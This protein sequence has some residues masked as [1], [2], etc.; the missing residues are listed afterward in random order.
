[1][2][3]LERLQD[4][5]LLKTDSYIGGKWQSSTKTFSVYNP[6]A[7]HQ[8]V[9]VSDAESTLAIQAILSARDALDGWKQTSATARAKA[10][11][12]WYALMIEAQSDLATILTWEQGKPLAE[13]AQEIA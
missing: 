7:T 10:L 4:K 3:L 6:A 5:G 11:L 2:A 9:E 13:A 12:R 1:M 8:I